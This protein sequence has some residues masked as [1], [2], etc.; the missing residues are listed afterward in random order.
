M[1]PTPDFDLKGKEGKDYKVLEAFI[2]VKY[3]LYEDMYNVPLQ[4]IFK[5]DFKKWD[6][7]DFK[8]ALFLHLHQLIIYLYINSIYISI[9]K[10]SKITK[11]IYTIYKEFILKVQSKNNI[12]YYLNTSKILSL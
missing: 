6:F 2:L 11:N 4:A 8:K 3:T 9:N 5:Q 12:R 10:S 1:A 7:E